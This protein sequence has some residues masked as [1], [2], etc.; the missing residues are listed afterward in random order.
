MP[1]EKRNRDF[2]TTARKALGLG[3]K[4]SLRFEP[5]PTARR[6]GQ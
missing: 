2:S 4:P 5:Q 1:V 3:T 6:T